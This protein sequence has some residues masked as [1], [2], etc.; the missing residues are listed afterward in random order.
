MIKSFYNLQSAQYY[1]N[2]NGCNFIISHECYQ[3]YVKD[4][5]DDVRKR[6]YIVFPNIHE[7]IKNMKKYPYSHELLLENSN[8]YIKDIGRLV[9]D[10]DFKI[11]YYE[12]FMH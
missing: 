5:K 3:P 9:F 10:F 6:D 1:A 11:R 12:N 7:Y 8:S 2:E 4:G